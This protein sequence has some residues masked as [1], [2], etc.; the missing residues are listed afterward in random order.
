[1]TPSFGDCT[2]GWDGDKLTVRQADPM[3]RITAELVD[4]LERGVT[5]PDFTIDGDV[6]TINAANRRVVYRLD[7]SSYDLFTNTYRMQWPD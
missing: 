5:H 7:R 3:V 6:I 1:M 4:E 2:L